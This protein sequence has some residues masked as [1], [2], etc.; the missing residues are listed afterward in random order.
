MARLPKSNSG[1]TAVSPLPLRSL[2]SRP[3]TPVEISGSATQANG[4]MATFY[5]IQTLPPAEPGS[6]SFLTVIA[7][8]STGFVAGDVITV[9]GRAAKIWGTVL[10][11]DLDDQRPGIKGVWKSGPETFESLTANYR[12]AASLYVLINI[13]RV[14]ENLALVPSATSR[15]SQ[16]LT[17]GTDLLR[18]LLLIASRTR[19]R[20]SARPRFPGRPSF[21]P[22]DKVKG[23]VMGGGKGRRQTAV[24][25]MQTNCCASRSP[26]KW[27]STNSS[28]CALT[29]S[30]CAPRRCPSIPGGA[31]PCQGVSELGCSGC[32]GCAGAC[33]TGVSLFPDSC[34]CLWRAA[35]QVKD[36]AIARPRTTAVTPRTAGA[37][38]VPLATPRVRFWRPGY[39]KSGTAWRA[40]RTDGRRTPGI[41]YPVP[42][43]VRR[44][45]Y[46]VVLPALARRR[47]P[48]AGGR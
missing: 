8:P 17:L 24:V 16:S 18:G 4:A 19:A 14:C 39:R 30:I 9:V 37:I 27:G 2:G 31:G 38:W 23:E 25:G 33:V 28:I 34:R 42:A 35:G 46:Q 6:G 13:P 11:E 1:T 22:R 48:G 45:L 44:G 20:F 15:S 5:D 12:R 32:G 47:A 7:V 43:V 29:L 36:R 41:G 40:Q 10:Y 21:D 3:A 26:S